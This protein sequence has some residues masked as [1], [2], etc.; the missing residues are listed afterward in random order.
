[1][2]TNTC[3]GA[4]TMAQPADTIDDTVAF[5]YGDAYVTHFK[6]VLRT[7]LEERA[8]LRQLYSRQKL[9]LVQQFTDLTSIQ[10]HVYQDR[11]S[12]MS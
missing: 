4:V 1:M 3:D 12:D 8:D 10:H 7:V 6:L 2:E 9:A 11:L 5:M